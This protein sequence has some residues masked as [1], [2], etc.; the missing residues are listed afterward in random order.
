MNRAACNRGPRVLFLW[1]VPERLREYLRRGLVGVDL[2]LDF[3][4]DT[5]SAE[6]IRRAPGAAA[7]VGWRPTAELLEAAGELRLF[8]NPGAG[9]QHLVE[10]FRDFSLR[11]PEH[12]VT[13]V[14]GHG[15][16]GF[17]AQHTVALLLALTNR[18]VPHHNWMVQGRWR[19]GDAEAASLPLKDRRIG[20]LG[21]G[22]VN[23]R[24]HRLLVA[25][26]PRFATL[27]R[28]WSGT[29][30]PPGHLDRY[31]SEELDRFLDWTDVLI[32]CL[33]QTAATTG[34]IGAAEL[35][36]LGPRGLLVN[37]GRGP[38]IDEE[39]LYTA[40]R[41]GRIA[42]AAL[43][44]WYDYRPEPDYA[45][46]RRPH[47][48]PFHELNNVVLSPHRAASPFDD[49]GRWDEVICN[50]TRLVA[51]RRDFL[52]IVDLERGY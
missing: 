13:L 46:R 22:H 36:R 24:V 1:N 42:G 47:R 33:P 20:L 23:R 45:G 31:T 4:E 49:L 17:T 38:I 37:V 28:D 6:L 43:D 15:N 7:L 50:L 12:D 29:V 41:T 8:I 19:T 26:G 5:S 21:Y 14:N 27:R 34:L 44:V 2:E 18:V 9:V 10:L 25:F 51:G 16:A 11:H 35:D 30:E 32:I 52:N 3:P 39:A 40:L 48:H